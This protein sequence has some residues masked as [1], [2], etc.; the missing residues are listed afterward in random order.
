GTR[1]VGDKEQAATVSCYKPSLGDLRY[2]VG[3]GLTWITPMGPLTF[4]LAK[5]L[6]EEQHDQ[7]QVFQFSLG[8]PF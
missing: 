4:S 2:S 8:T 3:L 5:A 6:K 7:T 1:K